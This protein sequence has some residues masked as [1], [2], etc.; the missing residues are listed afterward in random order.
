MDQELQESNGGNIGTN[1]TSRE[2]PSANSGAYSLNEALREKE[3]TIAT[4]SDEDA[5]SEYFI[6][7]IPLFIL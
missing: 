4:N 7:I 3:L 5:A 1:D 6:E 2:E